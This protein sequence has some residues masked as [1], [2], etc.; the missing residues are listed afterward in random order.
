[1]EL[2]ALAQ[3]PGEVDVEALAV[4]AWSDPEDLAEAAAALD[5][6]LGGELARA[7]AA[8]R[9]SGE[10][11][12]AE[13]VALLPPAISAPF[14]ARAIIGLGLGPF[15]QFDAHAARTAAAA[16]ARKAQELKLRQ[17]AVC[18]PAH[19]A[20]DLASPALQGC[21]A[22]EGV[23]LAEY[24]YDAYKTQ[25][26]GPPVRLDS[27]T[28][29]VPPANASELP[30]LEAA[31]AQGQQAAEV[32]NFVRELVNGPPNRVT[33]AYLAETAQRVAQEEGLECQVL[34]K[35]ELEQQG[36]GGLL[37]V[38][39]GSAREPCLV[40]LRY[41]AAR[42]G[43]KTLAVVGKGI[44]FDSGGL[45]LKSAENMVAMHQDMAGAA[46]VI[47][48][49]KLAATFKLPCNVIGV[50][51][52]TEN[53]PSGTA[54]KPSDILRMYNGR[55]VEITNTDAE[56]RLVLADALA[57]AAREAPDAIVDL[58]TLTGANFVTFG[59]HAA[60][61][62]GNDEHLVELMR[63][64]GARSGE[65]AW[66]LPLWPEYRRQMDSPVAD[67]KN[68]A[69][70]A[71]SGVSAAGFLSEFVDRRPW[72]HL[73]IYGVAYVDADQKTVPPYNLRCT[74]TGFG[75]RLLREFVTLW[76]GA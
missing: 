56:G 27:F 63:L 44:T 5:A 68:S 12:R 20:S 19:E 22:A 13:L 39:Q 48:F 60:A 74:A 67:L 7:L 21:A 76:A 58:A 33:P 26:D 46:A 23:A 6:A 47:G 57:C 41:Q 35:A 69:G 16:G 17:L 36:M 51:G 25:V 55:T 37:A 34:W 42:S 4:G 52:A 14:R 75:P 71:A 15:R 24:R 45:S 38:N 50:F 8:H 29:V 43:A 62:I 40:R 61:A 59:N 53:L 10:L 28:A 73:D 49:L 65:R 30:A 70:R 66:P 72:V 32:T 1:M 31:L 9:V 64:A 54:Y 18:L 11:G 3:E 2:R